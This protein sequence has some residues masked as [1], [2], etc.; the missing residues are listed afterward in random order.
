M[1]N[2]VFRFAAFV[3]ITSTFAFADTS[4]VEFSEPIVSD[5]SL[6]T[7]TRGDLSKAMGHF[8]RAR[9]LVIAAVREFDAGLKITNPDA[10][11]DSAAWRN[12]LIG[13]AEELEA[14][15]AP[16]PRVSTGGVKYEAQPGLLAE[17]VK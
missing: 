5:T 2:K 17:S 16:Q 1:N 12:S 11:I 9:N 7:A 8:S 14:V 4:R 6:E 15:L 10:L 13:R 3:A